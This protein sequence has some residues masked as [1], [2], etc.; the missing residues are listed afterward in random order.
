MQNAL[1]HAKS[2]KNAKTR[3]KRE[4]TQN[5]SFLGNYRQNAQS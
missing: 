2:A 4:N 1:K 5:A 3:K